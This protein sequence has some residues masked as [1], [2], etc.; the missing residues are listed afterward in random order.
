MKIFER[1]RLI[2]SLLVAS[3][4]ANVGGVGYLASTGG[5]RR[6]LVKLDL[7]PIT[8]S[9]MP[10]QEQDEARFRKLP[11]GS[12]GVYFAGESHAA[13]GPWA[14]FYSEVHN[15]G[16]GGETTTGFLG[17]LDEVI[18]RRPRKLFL[19]LGTND[20]ASA[21]R[22]SRVVANYRAILERLR[23]ESPSTTVYVVGTLPVNRD[24]PEPDP[25]T[26]DDVREVNRGL[27]AM[28]DEF[29]NARFVD[30]T[31]VLV[32]ASGALKPEYTY[33]GTHLSVEGYLA[34]RKRLDPLVL[35][36]PEGPTGGEIK[37]K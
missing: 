28:I 37:A 13:G 15:R 30:L 3:V 33:D 35:G 21:S 7:L 19:L 5:L 27:A 34:T 16:I 12:G 14:E 10:F 26:N 8:S 20:L 32:D 18:A 2:N 29:P 31:D 23:S 17:R 4:A 24:F 22:P 11:G 36:G 6:V 9:R 25:F 1:R